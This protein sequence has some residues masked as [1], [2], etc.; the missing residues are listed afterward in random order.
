MAKLFNGM[1]PFASAIKP[2]GAQPLDDRTV[3]QSF[4]DLLAENTFGLAKYNGMLVAVIDDEQVYM[5]VD[6]ANSSSEESWV[7][8]GSGNGSVAVETYAEAIALAT[9]DNLGQVIYVKTESEYDADGEEG[10]GVSVKY[11]AAPY[12][13]IGEGSLMKLA[14]SSA[15]GDIEGDVAKLT[16]K[17]TKLEEVVG[18]EE[19]GLVKAVADNADAI[20]ELEDAVA[21]KVA[22]ADYD[23]K[24]EELNNAIAAK[25][26][27]ADYDKKVEELEDAID[28]KVDAVEGSRLMTNAEGEKLAK[29]ADGAQVNTI[30]VIKVNDVA[31]T[32][33]EA[34][35]SVNIVVPTAPV[36]G[37]AADE[38]L[39][40]LDG[41]KLKSTLTLAYVAASKN[42]NDEHVPAQLRLQGI[43]NEVISS[44]DAD[45]FV[46]DG[47]IEKVEL[48][49][50]NTDLGETGK[51]YLVITW[52]TES[53]KEVMRLDVSELFN[54]YT[55]SNGVV[56]TEGNFS[57]KLATGEQYLTVGTDGLATTE[58]LWNKVTEL[59]NAVIV[60][61]A[62]SAAT[63]EQNAKTH[64]DNL[65]TAMNERVVAL[66]ESEHEHANADVLSGISA[67]KVAAWDAAEQNAKSYADD[68]FVTKEGFNEFEAEYEEKLNG[69]AAGAE[70]NV[71]E[72]IKVNGKDAV[73]TDKL[74]EV[75][76]EAKD[77]ELGTPIT[78]NDEAIIYSA[79]TK[80][81]T[82]LQGIQDSIRAAVAGGVNS[83]TSSDNAIDLNNADPNNPKVSLKVEASSDETK[84][85]GHIEI[86]KGDNGIYGVMYYDGDDVE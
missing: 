15:S 23:A 78:G 65:N 43:N 40:S 52:N 46:K 21:A 66:E 85:A 17:V 6:A 63:A 70:V 60:A 7:A 5:L 58:A 59:D 76:I 26:A 31:L 45:K 13:V 8:V 19:S 41:D 48:D 4:S 12:I 29:I 50:P 3:V 54:P 14:A 69:I 56:L 57:L 42:E 22:Q 53:G 81:S 33:A 84:A 51:K 20:T 39:I 10:E 28:A 44:I 67:E 82:V 37:V 2:T 75:K 79:D 34:D 83:V 38:K 68:K 71:I 24:V 64:A 77:I 73:V 9:N 16:T 36:Q 1:I 72:S 74:A 11:D 49:G 55:A 27:Q 86:M 18:G 30:E 32:V 47:M 61:A 25:V 80:I 35:K 62:A